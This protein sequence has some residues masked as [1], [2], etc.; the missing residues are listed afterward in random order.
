MGIF[1]DTTV[2][3]HR[4]FIDGRLRV[5]SALVLPFVL[6]LGCAGAAPFVP[7][8]FDRSERIFELFDR[9]ADAGD[10]ARMAALFS[11]AHEHALWDDDT[12]LGRYAE[13]LERV[14]SEL[15]GARDA[16][17]YGAAIRAVES[18]R[19][20]YADPLRLE[21]DRPAVEVPNT[22]RLR[23][24][25]V[26]SLLVDEAVVPALE[27][28]REVDNLETVNSDT[29]IEYLTHARRVNN[30]ALIERLSRELAARG[31][32]SP[33]PATE[34]EQVEDR[35]VQMLSGTVTIWVNRGIRI[36]GGVGVPDRVIG[37]GFFIDPRGYLIT[38]YHVVESEVDPAYEGYSRLFVKLPGR[39]DQRV[40]A[41][42]VG[43]DR[44][45]DLALLK[46]EIDPQ[47]VFSFSD[48]R[49]L[50]PGQTVFALGSPG[51]DRKS[52]V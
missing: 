48:V 22:D 44:I 45:F 51:G 46:V 18:L 29:L 23:L 50:R 17:E 3:Q 49:R 1:P 52:V 4:R 39:N 26:E 31:V 33:Q 21:I 32:Q 15:S 20:L 13:L 36:R 5:F 35:P 16:G 43:Y 19:T 10:T 42:V 2:E 11:Y 12:L 41:R 37:S 7:T 14:E 47:Y 34:L 9:A 40:P 6:L 24:S 27:V 25:W 38:N 28:L 30:D 8:P